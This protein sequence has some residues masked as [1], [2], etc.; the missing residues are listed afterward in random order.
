MNP[1]TRAWQP[2]QPPDKRARKT[3]QTK[4]RHAQHDATVAAAIERRAPPALM[5]SS[6]VGGF[7]VST[8]D[9]IAKSLKQVAVEE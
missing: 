7:Q 3:A 6:A 5:Q 1:K 4:K 9:R 8:F 2:E